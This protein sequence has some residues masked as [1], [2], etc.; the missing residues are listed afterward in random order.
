MKTKTGIKYPTSPLWFVKPMVRKKSVSQSAIFTCWNILSCNCILLEA[1][2]HTLI[3][4]LFAY[5]INSDKSIKS[6][7][8]NPESLPSVKGIKCDEGILSHYDSIS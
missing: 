2:L 8:D 1:Y 4:I 3:C 5:F 6:D 7:Y